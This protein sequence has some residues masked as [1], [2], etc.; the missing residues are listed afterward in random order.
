MSSH[1]ADVFLSIILHNEIVI[2]I[3]LPEGSKFQLLHPH[4]I[5]MAEAELI[6]DGRIEFIKIARTP[7]ILIT[8]RIQLYFLATYVEL[9]G[10]IQCYEVDR[11][12]FV[13]VSEEYCVYE[14]GLLVFSDCLVSIFYLE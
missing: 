2:V 10:I 12:Y 3:T 11:H 1:L 6:L 9:V 14:T 4:E 5:F 7:F 13:S 8:R